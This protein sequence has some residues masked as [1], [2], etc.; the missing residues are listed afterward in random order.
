MSKGGDLEKIIAALLSS[1]RKEQ[2]LTLEE[3]ADRAG[4]H[5]T[6]VGLIER[7]E[8]GM[9][10]AMA[11]RLSEALGFRFSDLVRQAEERRAG[12]SPRKTLRDHFRNE[13]DLVRLTGLTHDMLSRG[14]ESC[15]RTLDIIDEQLLA[16]ESEPI[17]RLVELANLSSMLGNLL[18]AAV[19][20]A[21]AGL[22]ERNK[23]HTY[24]DLLPLK[25]RPAVPI[26]IK[27]A[28]EQNKPKGH[29]P[30]EGVYLTFRYVLTDAKGQYVR[31]R[32]ARG[33]TAWIWEV[34]AGRLTAA[35]FDLS[36]TAGDSG[37]TAV[38]KT[39]SLEAMP[40]AYYVPE[41]LP[42]AKADRYHSANRIILPSG[43]PVDAPGNKRSQAS[44]KQPR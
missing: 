3:A 12:R 24:P 16:R 8:R 13:K 22:Y 43:E 7:D 18:G 40:L 37:K 6:S 36:N 4:V 11:A 17:A 5:R 10:V 28:L 15:Y 34:R 1:A 23:P 9:T 21:S 42:Y 2:K 30:K 25:K 31:G 44:Q 29:L 27:T 35:D 20:D 38:V 39:K 33:D 14:I 26:E 41:Y 19:A 32:D